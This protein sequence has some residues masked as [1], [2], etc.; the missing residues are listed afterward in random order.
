VGAAGIVIDG[1]TRDAD[2]LVE[3]PFPTWCRFV[4]PVLSHGRFQVEAY[5]EPVSVGGQVAERV[6]V[7][8]GD[9][10]LG[11]GDGV[12]I[13]PGAIL[14]DVLAYA[15]AAEKGE[16]EI[17]KALEAGDDREAVDARIDRW[18]VL[19]ARRRGAL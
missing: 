13:V 3:M 15:E 18:A 10:V 12:V 5:N 8:P 6:Q 19:K 4:T 7:R 17:R 11:D 16:G 1:G 9:F 2:D 14:E